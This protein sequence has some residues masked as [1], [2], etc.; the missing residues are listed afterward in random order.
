[1]LS[2]ILKIKIL[3]ILLIVAAALSTLCVQAQQLPAAYYTDFA[4]AGYKGDIPSPTNI[5]T[6]SG[7]D[8]TGATDMTSIIQAAIN[9]VSGSGVVF[10]P[11][12]TYLLKSTLTLKSNVVLR[13]NGSDKTQLRFDLSGSDDLILMKGSSVGSN[14]SLSTNAARGSKSVMLSS[15]SGLEAGNVVYLYQSPGLKA[16]PGDSWA[17]SNNSLQVLHVKGVSGNTV[18]FE[19]PLRSTFSTANSAFVKKINAI[20]NAGV[21]DLRLECVNMQYSDPEQIN[22]PANDN[23]VVD[24]ADNCW[25]VGVEGYRSNGAHVD[26]RRCVNLQ[27]SGCYFH[28][29]HGYG[30]GGS[31][32]G[33]CLTGGATQVLVANCIFDSLRHAMLIQG[34]SNGNV[35]AYNYSARE[36]RT[37]STPS[38]MGGDA[39][40]HGN[41]AHSNLF[42][43]N[44]ANNMVVDNPHGAN[45]PRNVFLRNR[46]TSYGIKIQ[47]LR[48][49]DNDNLQ[50]NA[51]IGND[52]TVLIGNEVT[53][54]NERSGSTSNYYGSYTLESEVKGTLQMG[55][56]KQNTVT[57]NGTSAARYK[58]LY[59]LYQPL[60]WDIADSWTGIGENNGSSIPAKVRFDNASV[61]KTDS[62]NLLFANCVSV[63]PTARDTTYRQGETAKQLSAV[64]VNLKWYTAAVG[65][66]ASTTAPTPATTAT[67]MQTFY[68]TQTTGEC[69]ESSRTATTVT[70]LGNGNQS[71]TCLLRAFKIG[72]TNGVIKDS[73][74]RIKLPQGTDLRTL[75]PTLTISAKAAA[76]PASGVAQDFSSVVTYTITAENGVSKKRYHVTA[77]TSEP[78]GVEDEVLKGV[79]IFPNPFLEQVN[80]EVDGEA[81][82]EIYDTNGRLRLETKIY[83]SNTINTA[84]LEAGS[85]VIKVAVNGKSKSKI[86]IKG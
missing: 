4:Y 31:A 26:A 12:G 8:N 29:G 16:Y 66:T 86:M 1:M 60:F 36:Y 75:I 77:S 79:K 64:G 35:F 41:W 46:F 34:F 50:R 44:I 57:P 81:K 39:I 40:L 17:Q 59:N 43:G 62:R 68:V 27:I 33:V 80:V 84:S 3:H 18:T 15:T 23:I 51:S 48:T 9:G 53:H 61:K 67:G 14:L 85:Y 10:L 20:T 83:N 30:G 7:L 13:G 45:G 28:H 58:T 32:Y 49:G 47:N 70:I 42:Q 78:T 11:Q 22:S 63:P 72:I 24:Y 76:Q 21:E 38:D 25:I 65:G 2:K 37:V 54:K 71:D 69:A 5:A 52:S 82:V 56:Y 19:E 74:V 73:I 55:N 6:P